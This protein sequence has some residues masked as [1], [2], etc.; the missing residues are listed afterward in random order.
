MVELATS[1]PLQD[2]CIAQ[3]P[4]QAISSL[5]TSVP[6]LRLHHTSSFLSFVLGK[7][8]RDTVR[9]LGYESYDWEEALVTLL[10][11]GDL[12]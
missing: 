2:H 12:V 4:F 7:E 10:T 5:L 6:N 8:G 11:M 9:R 3:A 1:T